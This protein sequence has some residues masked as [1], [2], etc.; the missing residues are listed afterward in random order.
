MTKPLRNSVPNEPELVGDQHAQLTPR[1]R[2]ILELLKAGK[3]NKEIANEL[4]IGL[5]TVKQHMVAL[6]KKLGVRNRTMAVS[7]GIS[8]DQPMQ[9]ASDEP[10]VLAGVLERRPCVVLCMIL[11]AMSSEA[12]LGLQQ[13]MT[14]FALANDGLLLMRKERAVEL[15]FGIQACSE[16]D[17]YKAYVAAYKIFELL[18]GSAKDE[19]VLQAAV[20][21]GVAIVS[22][23][24]NGGCT[25]DVIASPVIGLARDLAEQ[26]V[27]GTIQFD[28]LAMSLLQLAQPDRVSPESVLKVACLQRMPWDDAQ[29]LPPMFGRDDEWRQLQSRLQGLQIGQK[30]LV[31]LQGETGMGKSLF[32]HHLAQSF[33]NQGGVVQHFVCQP[34]QLGQQ[35]FVYPSGDALK[36]ESLPAYLQKEDIGCRRLVILDDCQ[37]LRSDILEALVQISFRNKNT[38]FVLVGRRLGHALQA[39]ADIIKLDR[40]SAHAINQIVGHYLHTGD[41]DFGSHIVQQAHGVPLFAR[42]LAQSGTSEKSLPFI[43]LAVIAARMDGLKLDRRLLAALAKSTDT[44]TL[45]SIAQRLHES[46]QDVRSAMEKAIASGVLR[47]ADQKLFFTHPLLRQAVVESL[48]E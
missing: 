8:H 32:C 15:I 27:P 1:Q 44:E 25:G 23:K 38:V 45:E 31:G 29:D 47:Q 48:V 13:S 24:R 26:A 3:V 36:I 7:Q 37:Y 10:L 30:S 39:H 16:F 35:V 22:M 21:A 5:G 17:V 40:L 20:A 43:L 41:V 46:L 18:Q 4:G 11:P 19:Q 42:V 9:P 28:A 6:F 12:L 34:K 14:I 33:K 2:Q